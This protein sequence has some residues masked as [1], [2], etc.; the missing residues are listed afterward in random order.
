MIDGVEFSESGE[1]P[2]DFERRLIAQSESMTHWLVIARR[3]IAE[4]GETAGLHAMCVLLDELGGEKIHIPRRRHL[5]VRL[6]RRER[7]GLIRQLAQPGS[8]WTINELA[9]HFGVSQP[10]AS[11]VARDTAADDRHA[12]A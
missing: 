9:E 5:F 2:T 3:L 7:D 8:G 11:R 1:A 6:W 12:A 4:L 10:Y